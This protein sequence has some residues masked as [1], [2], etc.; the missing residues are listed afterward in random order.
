L[1]LALKARISTELTEYHGEYAADYRIRHRHE[2]CRYFSEEAHHEHDDGA[3]EDHTTASDL[4][5]S[6]R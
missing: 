1:D 4:K 2:Q 3:V 6:S 5:N